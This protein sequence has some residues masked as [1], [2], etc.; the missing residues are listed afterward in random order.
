VRHPGNGPLHVVGP[1]GGPER[2]F[3]KVQLDLG[4]VQ[5]G[6]SGHLR[7]ALHRLFQSDVDLEGPPP[8]LPQYL[9]RLFQ[10]VHHERKPLVGEG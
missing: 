1:P 9:K 7:G 3:A 5:S 6:F 8:E 10:P 2:F 4:L